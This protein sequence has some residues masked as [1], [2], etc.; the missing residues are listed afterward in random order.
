M[1]ENERI[2]TAE[3]ERSATRTAS[4]RN[5]LMAAGLAS[6][7]IA[8][9]FVVLALASRE[10]ER[11]GD[12]EPAPPT[13]ALPAGTEVEPAGAEALQVESGERAGVPALPAHE[14]ERDGAGGGTES[15]ASKSHDEVDEILRQVRWD[16]LAEA[17]TNG[18]E[19]SEG[20]PIG[21]TGRAKDASERLD[22]LS[23]ELAGRV[24]TASGNGRGEIT[25][26]RVVARVVEA[27]LGRAGAPLSLEQTSELRKLAREYERAIAEA[28]AVSDRSA[29]LERLIDEIELKESFLDDLRD[30]LTPAQRDALEAVTPGGGLVPKALEPFGI[31]ELENL[32]SQSNPGSP[33]SRGKSPVSSACFPIVLPRS[34]RCSVE[35]WHRSSIGGP[36][37]S[38]GRNAR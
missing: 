17:I 18:A 38:P 4:K 32:R 28:V 9:I 34:L 33:A 29:R 2:G 23:M 25:H 7:A 20:A 21:S 14:R 15:I 35:A 26:P 1:R 11:T 27:L 30:A 8:V 3:R 19:K 31:A 13:A 5:V 12:V 22:Q 10:D 24:A 16:R 36:P 37:I 6:S